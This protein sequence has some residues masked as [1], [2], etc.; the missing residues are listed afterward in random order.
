M[1]K[2]REEVDVFEK[3]PVRIE[4]SVREFEIGMA[5]PFWQAMKVQLEAWIED[6]RDNLEDPDNIYL[7]RTLRRL[8]GNAQALRYVMRLP[9]ITLKNLE[10]GINEL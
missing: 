2:N 8:G 7:E 1:P 5:S 3:P 6:I 9:E 4:C 10:D